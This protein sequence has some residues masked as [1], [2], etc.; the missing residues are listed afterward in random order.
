MVEPTEPGSGDGLTRRERQIMEIIY[1]EGEAS[2]KTVMEQMSDPP[3]YATVRTLL[4]V[5][6]EKRILQHRKEG[7]TYIYSSVRSRTTEG[8]SALQRVMRSF[9]GGSL[10]Q[11]MACLLDES[12]RSELDAEELEKLEQMIQE[13]KKRPGGGS[14]K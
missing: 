7:K 9:F 6:E 4:R 3:T 10:E 12:Q 1:A 5:L 14:Q 8:K 11:V 13:A 2:A